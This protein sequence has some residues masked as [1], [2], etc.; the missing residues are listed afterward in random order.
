M[1]E[2]QSVIYLLCGVMALHALMSKHHFSFYLY[3]DCEIKH[4]NFQRLE[5][6][7]M[8]VLPLLVMCLY[9]SFHFHSMVIRIWMILIVLLDFVL[10]YLAKECGWLSIDKNEKIS[11][12]L[13][14]WVVFMVALFFT[15]KS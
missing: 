13:I 5:K 1:S 9:T 4:K 11:S 7:L 12:S 10:Q 8:I 14:I 3:K 2:D 6:I 15:I